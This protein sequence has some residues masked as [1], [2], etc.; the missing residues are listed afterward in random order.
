MMRFLAHPLLPSD[1]KVTLGFKAK[2]FV[3]AAQDKSTV[4]RHLSWMATFPEER[5][6]ELPGQVRVIYVELIQHPWD[7]VD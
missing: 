7:T 6:C 3:R 4:N 1:Q 5:R 2:R